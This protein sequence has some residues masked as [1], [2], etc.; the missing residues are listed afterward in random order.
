M[1]IDIIKIRAIFSQSW[2]KINSNIIWEAAF[3]K[4]SILHLG[5][6]QKIV[7]YKNMSMIKLGI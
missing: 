7:F 4:F 2:K 6:R 3:C 1:N 5:I